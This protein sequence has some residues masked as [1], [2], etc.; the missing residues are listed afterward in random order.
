MRK[1]TRKRKFDEIRSTRRKYIFYLIYEL[2]TYEVL[3]KL[4]KIIRKE[5]TSKDVNS[6]ITS[7]E[8]SKQLFSDT[9]IRTLQTRSVMNKF[10]KKKI[11]ERIKTSFQ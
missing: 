4:T 5:N 2:H 11:S 10:N 6:F 8:K 7:K 9:R 1:I 3:E